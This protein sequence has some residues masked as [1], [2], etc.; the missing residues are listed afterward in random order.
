MEQARAM[1][2]LFSMFPRG[3]PGL[4]LLLLRASTAVALLSEHYAYAH[5]LSTG[6]LILVLLISLA[7]S[8]GYLTPIAVAGGLLAHAWIWVDGAAAHRSSRS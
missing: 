1:Q 6:P 2:R 8:V 3:R 5:S 7:I 4:A